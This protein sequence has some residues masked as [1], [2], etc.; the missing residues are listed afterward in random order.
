MANKLLIAGLFW[1]SGFLI[2]YARCLSVSK[3]PGA[4]K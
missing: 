2:G 4:S 1:I 3:G